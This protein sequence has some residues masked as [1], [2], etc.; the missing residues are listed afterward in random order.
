MRSY[1]K[2]NTSRQIFLQFMY[3]LGIASV[4]FCVPDKVH[5]QDDQNPQRGFHPAGSYALSGIE[6]IN[7]NNGNLML[8]L[9]LAS[10]PAGRGGSLSASVGLFYNSKNWD[11]R[12]SIWKDIFDNTYTDHLLRDSPEG[13]WRYG[14]EYKPQLTDRL[15][16]YDE[17]SRPPCGAAEAQMRYKLQVSFPDGSL[18]EFRPSGYSDSLADGYFFI[19]PD[20]W[21]TGCS[22]DSPL[23]SGPMIYYSTDGTYLR[24]E[25]AHDG[26]S[27][28]TN[29]PWT[30]YFPDGGRVTTHLRP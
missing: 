14:F 30:L 9:P 29:N 3:I 5:A 24:L 16:Q 8:R 21:A 11:S 2:K 7:T 18:H 4:L 6:T 15:D 17:Y 28:W 22:G 26:D 12:I 20:G 25:F 1:Q 19:R 23:V 27:N 13:G 10:L